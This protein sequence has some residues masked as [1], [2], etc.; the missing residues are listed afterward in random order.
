MVS[1]RPARSRKSV[2]RALESEINEYELNFIK[3]LM[4]SERPARSRESALRALEAEI[5]KFE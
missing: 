2:P 3:T 4:V 1:E 5:N